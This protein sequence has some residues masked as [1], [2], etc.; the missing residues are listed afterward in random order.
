MRSR[1]NKIR[2]L[3]REEGGQDLSEYCLLLALVV[4]IA[5]GVFLKVSGGVQ[6]LWAVA[7]TTINSTAASTSVTSTGSAQSH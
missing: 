2:R 1:W 7:D 6:S 4:L 3:F 5:A